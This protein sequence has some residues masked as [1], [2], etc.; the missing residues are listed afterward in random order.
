ME[1]VYVLDALRTPLVAKG[2]GLSSVRPETFT[3]ELVRALC[4]RNGITS[5]DGIL[6]GNA[7]G[8]GGNLTRLMALMTGL[9][10]EI[11]SY[12]IDT[13]CAS[14]AT[15]LSLGFGQIAGGIWNICIAGGF[16]SISLQ[17]LRTYH[18]K[19]DRYAQMPEGKGAYY[20]AQFS[21]GELSPKAML[22][23]AERTAQADGITRKEL[24]QWALRSHRRAVRAQASGRLNQDIFPVCG[25]RRDDGIRP[26][27]KA[28]LLNRMPPLLGPGTVT[29][30]GNS[31]RT[32]DGAAFALLV[33]GRWLKAHPTAHA[34]ARILD[35]FSTGGDPLE[36]PRGAMRTA[37]G[38]LRRQRLSWEVLSAIEFNEAFAVID[39]LFERQHPQLIH[40][41]NRL[42]GALAYGHPYGASG[43]VLLIHLLHSL[44]LAGGGKGLLSIAGA[45]GMG[46][47]ILLEACK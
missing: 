36:S 11:P 22:Q 23:G 40:R 26:S 4:Q 44:D 8:T 37:D 13:Q 12:T 42:G 20:M 25:C 5:V 30:A 33:S 14:A 28:E 31:C 6:G 46:T 39:V 35:V 19:D 18:A 17:P 1:R 21:P 16:E 29:T 27:M 45:G 24:D 3:A 10:Q 15:A 9:P 7:V 2:K 34:K 32:N 38:L 43:T 41:Y 47:A